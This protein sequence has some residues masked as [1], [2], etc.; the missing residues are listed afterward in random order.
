MLEYVTAG[1]G[2]IAGIS[3]AIAYVYRK[4]KSDGMDDACENRI[5]KDI[6]DLGEKVDANAKANDTVHAQ[7]FSNVKDIGTK[8]DKLQGSSE[9]IQELITNHLTK[10]D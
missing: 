6:H 10:K 3:A 8:I 1:L 4:G 7:L 9:V 5:K 2:V